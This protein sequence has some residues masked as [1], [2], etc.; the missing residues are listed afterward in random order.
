M[1]HVVR[2]RTGFGWCAIVCLAA[3]LFVSAN[4]WAQDT[5]D[6][7]PTAGC[8]F[9]GVADTVKQV[10]GAY[11]NAMQNGGALPGVVVNMTTCVFRR[12]S[13]RE[14]LRAV[15]ERVATS[16]DADKAFQLAIKAKDTDGPYYTSDLQKE[17]V[18]MRVGRGRVAAHEGNHVVLVSWQ[19]VAPPRIH[20]KDV[21]GDKLAPIA[22]A[23]LHAAQQ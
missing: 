22:L 11:D 19:V 18:Q 14:V 17:G 16:Q 21:P 2:P 1:K 13:S 23:V 9:K 5:Q 4:A 8:S 10:F 6:P 3:S 12:A 15:L 7:Q 20:S